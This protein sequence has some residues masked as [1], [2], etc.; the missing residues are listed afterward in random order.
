MG[1][2]FWTIVSVFILIW[3]I[4]I[5]IKVTYKGGVDVLEMIKKLKQ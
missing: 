4:V 2:W 5:T 3:Y 1:F